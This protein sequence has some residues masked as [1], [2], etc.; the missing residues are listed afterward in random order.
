VLDVVKIRGKNRFKI[1]YNENQILL[2][3]DNFKQNVGSRALFMLCGKAL[4]R[5]EEV[6]RTLSEEGLKDFIL[7]NLPE[8]FIRNHLQDRFDLDSLD[9]DENNNWFTIRYRTSKDSD[10]LTLRYF[11]PEKEKVAHVDAINDPEYITLPQKRE[12]AMEVIDTANAVTINSPRIAFINYLQ[13]R[14]SMGDSIVD[15]PQLVASLSAMN[16]LDQKDDFL[17]WIATE[18]WRK[19][20]LDNS[21]EYNFR[22]LAILLMEMEAHNLNAPAMKLWNF[23]SKKFG[24]SPFHAEVFVNWQLNGNRDQRNDMLRISKQHGLRAHGT[25]NYSMFGVGKYSA[26]DGFFQNEWAMLN[27]MVSGNL[28]KGSTGPLVP[29]KDEGRP[30]YAAA[31]YGPFYVIVDDSQYLSRETKEVHLA[32]HNINRKAQ[33]IYLVPSDRE[34]FFYQ[35]GIR[36]ALRLGLIDKQNA[37]DALSKLMTYGQFVA[38]EKHIPEIIT[39]KI[40]PIDVIAVERASPNDTRMA[41]KAADSERGTGDRM[42]LV[43][44]ALVNT[45]YYPEW[46][47][48]VVKGGVN[49]NKTILQVLLENDG[50]AQLLVDAGLYIN[51]ITY[52][53]SNQI[54]HHQVG[55][56]PHYSSEASY[57]AARLIVESQAFN[58]QQ[59]NLEDDGMSIWTKIDSWDGAETNKLAVLEMSFSGRVFNQ[60]SY[61]DGSIFDMVGDFMKEELSDIITEVDRQE[62][63]GFI[64]D[65]ILVLYNIDGVVEAYDNEGS[66]GIKSDGNF[67]VK[68]LKSISNIRLVTR[69]RDDNVS[70]GTI[71]EADHEGS[72]KALDNQLERQFDGFRGILGI[73]EKRDLTEEEADEAL[74]KLGH[75]ESVKDLQRLRK[76]IRKAAKVPRNINIFFSIP[77]DGTELFWVGEHYGAGHYNKAGTRMHISLPFIQKKG[78]KAG[79]GV[80]DHELAHIQIGQH[81]SISD[82][83]E[84]LLAQAIQN[85]LSSLEL[86][87]RVFPDETERTLPG[88]NAVTIDVQPSHT[89]FGDIMHAIRLAEGLRNT[90]YVDTIRLLFESSD[91]LLSLR[92]LFPELPQDVKELSCFERNG[93]IFINGEKVDADSIIR[94]S[95]VAIVLPLMVNQGFIPSREAAINI[96]LQEYD[97]SRELGS[98]RCGQ[99]SDDFRETLP[100]TVFEENKIYKDREGNMHLVLPTGFRSEVGVHIV[101]ETEEEQLLT[102]KR[103]I[104]AKIIESKPITAFPE[105]VENDRWSL[106]YS[107]DEDDYCE[108]YEKPLTKAIEAGKVSSEGIC[109]FNLIRTKFFNVKDD[110]KEFYAYSEFTHVFFDEKTGVPRYFAGKKYPEVKILHVEQLPHNICASIM[111]TSELPIMITGDQSLSEAVSFDKLYIYSQTGFKGQVM[112]SLGRLAMQLLDPGGADKIQNIIK[113]ALEAEYL[114]RLF[115]DSEYQNAVHRLN[116]LIIEKRNLVSNLTTKITDM[117]AQYD[118]E[119]GIIEVE[120]DSIWGK[121]FIDAV[122]M[123]AQTLHEKAIAGG[124]HEETIDIGIETSFIPRYTPR[125]D[126]RSAQHDS[127]NPVMT[128]LSNLED[129]LKSIGI[130]NVRFTIEDNPENLYKALPESAKAN[131]KNLILLAGKNLQAGKGE[132]PVPQILSNLLNTDREKSA[133]LALVDPV[134]FNK[135]GAQVAEGEELNIRILQMLFIALKK[136]YNEKV[137]YDHSHI[138]VRPTPY[139]GVIMLIP[140]A[141]KV[142]LEL[143]NELN[144]ARR[145]S[146]ESA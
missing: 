98:L 130:K 73:E 63:E 94:K 2:R 57:E 99:V 90:G 127:M 59:A 129:K 29:L 133:L 12:I 79:I 66:A 53:V 40:K 9:Y 36:E 48:V 27:I 41:R 24:V 139:P 47:S 107:H 135:P 80:A 26:Q 34:V 39:R 33:L 78:I 116:R 70:C 58:Y 1:V 95:K 44:R 85:D 100:E 96:Y 18:D 60:G 91:D 71:C 138:K 113:P 125:N 117:V 141:E 142:K 115:Y 132:S 126:G 19:Y 23:L 61:K 3:E 6:K 13:G 140:D 88:I 102:D 7:N 123:R 84:K 122:I 124:G 52:S 93:L 106:V 109:I 114:P 101:G 56:S 25:L 69:P 43:A 143:L 81:K 137:L 119:S 110:I 28:S 121:R 45:P 30:N 10:W 11:I 104:I 42:A 54:M 50:L 37:D 145:A 128:F 22:D 97:V 38:N 111:K 20:G 75:A 83:L 5:A 77:E 118:K 67:K 64:H 55:L 51:P 92:R 144:R 16:K 17:D 74:V 72:Y 15:L 32:E 103:D 136:R 62:L 134:E 65:M 21:N 35:E 46:L 112:T 120:D 89:G 49:K 4:H 108:R 8:K 105:G 87:N 86:K 131:P 76:Q 68:N 31:L 146:M 82:D 14:L